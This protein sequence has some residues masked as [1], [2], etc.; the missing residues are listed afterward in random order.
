MFHKAICL[1]PFTRLIYDIS[2]SEVLKALRINA[3]ARESG[4]GFYVN[5]LDFRAFVIV[6]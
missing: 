6:G 2:F 4:F 5:D 3:V 1:N